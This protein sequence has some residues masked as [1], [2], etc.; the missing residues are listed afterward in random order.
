MAPKQDFSAFC[1][2]PP[3]WFLAV[4]TDYPIEAPRERG[5]PR[6]A[7]FNWNPVIGWARVRTGQDDE[8]LV[9]VVF[10]PGIGMVVMDEFRDCVNFAMLVPESQLP[11]KQRRRARRWMGH[12]LQSIGKFARMQKASAHRFRSQRP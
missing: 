4:H 3:G 9:P 1:P 11:R 7:E 5:L 8:D 12:I 6:W 10:Q 2:S